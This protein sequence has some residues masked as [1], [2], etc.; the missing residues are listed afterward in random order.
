MHAGITPL[1][2]ERWRDPTRIHFSAVGIFLGIITRQ[3]NTFCYIPPL[4]LD[5]IDIIVD[6]QV[7]EITEEMYSCVP[8][9]SFSSP[10]HHFRWNYECVSSMSSVQ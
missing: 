1:T 2:R 3:F 10:R 8:S 6:L 7:L 5:V 4:I 9:G